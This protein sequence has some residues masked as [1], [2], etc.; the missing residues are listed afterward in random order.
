[1]LLVY[2]PNSK[3]L[4]I[5]SFNSETTQGDEIRAQLG[6]EG[7]NITFEDVN[8]ISQSSLSSPTYNVIYANQ[9]NTP[10]HPHSSTTLRK[11]SS[12]LVPNGALYLKQPVLLTPQNLP[13]VPVSRSTQDLVGELKLAGFVDIEIRDAVKVSR[14][15]IAKMI[16]AWQVK[17]PNQKEDILRALD[18]Q[19]HIVE[20][21]AK[22]PAYETGASF[23][24]KLGSKSGIS[25]GD[26]KSIWTMDFH[27]GLWPDCETSGKRKACKNCSCGLAEQL[28]AEAKAQTTIP[29]ASSCGNCSLGDAF[30]CATCPYLGMPSFKPEQTQVYENKL[31]SLVN[32]QTI[33]IIPEFT[34]SSGVKIRQVPVAYKTWGE[35]NEQKDNVMVICHA[36]SGSAD[37]E[38]W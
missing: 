26:R 19:L 24:L 9:Y 14:E 3:I 29:P 16:E 30:R 17:E 36:L 4:V 1:M 12:S 20:I 2:D 38:D 37:V 18:G 25:G 15:D 28:E 27:L 10:L 6:A 34:L 31:A 5:D 33:T 22:K 13:N 21:I 7:D 32:G 8:Q 23:A 35:L 11:L